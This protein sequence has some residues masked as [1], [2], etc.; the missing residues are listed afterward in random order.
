MTGVSS[1]VVAL[2]K[3]PKVADAFNKGQDAGIPSETEACNGCGDDDEVVDGEHTLPAQVPVAKET[4]KQQQEQ[5]KLSE[6]LT[7]CL[8]ATIW[9]VAAVN[10]WWCQ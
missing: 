2:G 8:H 3:H 6:L 5:A 1:A 10:T 7:R 9:T 4:T